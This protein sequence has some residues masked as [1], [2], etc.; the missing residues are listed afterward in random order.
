MRKIQVNPFCRG[1]YN[2][3]ND[4]SHL[5]F[6]L[7]IHQGN[8]LVKTSI[9]SLKLPKRGSVVWKISVF[10]LHICSFLPVCFLVEFPWEKYLKIK[11]W[12]AYQEILIL[13]ISVWE[14][15]NNNQKKWLRTINFLSCFQNLQSP[16]GWIFDYF[17]A[18]N[19]MEN[20]ISTKISVQL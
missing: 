12:K 19:K 16:T 3:Y 2:N 8:S 6:P 9:T 14:Y 10:L 11:L 7:G 17:M 20:R 4:R 1:V 15:L 13:Q 18:K 5:I